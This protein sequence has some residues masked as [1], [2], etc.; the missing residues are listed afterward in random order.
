MYIK[1]NDWCTKGS[2][3]NFEGLTLTILLPRVAVLTRTLAEDI[4]VEKSSALILI[5]IVSKVSAFGIVQ[6]LIQTALHAIRDPVSDVQG[7]SALSCLETHRLCGLCINA[8]GAQWEN[9]FYWYVVTNKEKNLPMAS[10]TATYTAPSLE[11]IDIMLSL[12]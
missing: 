8:W 3:R 1:C 4:T 6:A 7:L 12:R 9:V 11:D 2:F 5:L 10:K